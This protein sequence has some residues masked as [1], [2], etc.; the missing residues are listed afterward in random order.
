[1][2]T[3]RIYDLVV[4]EFSV[5]WAWPLFFQFAEFQLH[6]VAAWPRRQHFF[7]DGG[8]SEW[9]NAFLKPMLLTCSRRELG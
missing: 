3:F 8:G 7:A 6:L 4:Q 1:M 5:A 9:T 2:S